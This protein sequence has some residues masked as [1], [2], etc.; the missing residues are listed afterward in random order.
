M[1]IEKL[2]GIPTPAGFQYED[3]TLNKAAEQAI[4]HYV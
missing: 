3:V 2:C 4:T 1:L